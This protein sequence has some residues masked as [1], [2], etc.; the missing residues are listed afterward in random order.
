MEARQLTAGDL[1]R[2]AEAVDGIRDVPAYVVW[3]KDGPVITKNPPAPEDVIFECMTKSTK[4][5]RTKLRSIS[6]DPAVVT[7][8]GK[9]MADVAGKFDA[10]FWS[11][12]AVQKFVLPYYM[13]VGTADEVSR[14]L[15]AFNHA[16]VAAMLHLPDST[17]CVLTSVRSGSTLQALTLKEFEASL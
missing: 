11:E 13:H 8:D 3:G 14:V 12:S 9:P 10:M 4:P 17:H 7:P 16:T 5:D 1:R 6:L 2:L 15:R